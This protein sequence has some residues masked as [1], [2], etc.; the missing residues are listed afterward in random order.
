MRSRWLHTDRV[1]YA[2][3]RRAARA[4]AALI[5][6]V[7]LAGCA[8]EGARNP[9]N[10]WLSAEPSGRNLELLVLAQP[11][12]CSSFDDIEVQETDRLVRIHATVRATTQRPCP[13]E[14]DY[15]WVPIRLDTPLGDRLLTGCA[16]LD[17]RLHPSPL[18]CNDV[19]QPGEPPQVGVLRPEHAEP[20]A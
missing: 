14:P 2:A 8:G 15:L 17:N 3:T 12:S 9:T 11:R 16:P 13:P 4:L 5:G 1:R 6:A 7:V 10:W 20:G 18:S 19:E